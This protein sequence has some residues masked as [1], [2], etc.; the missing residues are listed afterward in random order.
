MPKKS[1]VRDMWDAYHAGRSIENRNRLVEHYYYLCGKHVR[2]S[3]LPRWIHDDLESEGVFG[4]IEAVERFSLD[5]KTQFTTFATQ[6]IRGRMRDWIRTQDVKPR[7]YRTLEKRFEALLL[8]GIPEK[9]AIATVFVTTFQYETHL[10]FKD[11]RVL[12]TDVT[13]GGYSD[14][15]GRESF[16]GVFPTCDYEPNRDRVDFFTHVF[17]L[18]PT[19]RHR[20]IA[21]MYFAGDRT[22]KEIGGELDISESR[23]S[24]IMT[25]S[26]NILKGKLNII[27]AY[28]QG[29]YDSI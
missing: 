22:M 17:R 14:M 6:F 28:K 11:L 9:E 5:K 15:N 10:H 3:T 2:M 18:L 23:I 8:Q 4:L 27:T 19:R 21:T 13:V 20:N 12:S 24:Q 7:R 1:P 26:L 16:F 29:L 25:E